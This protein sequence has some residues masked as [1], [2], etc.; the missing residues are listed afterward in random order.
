MIGIIKLQHMR[1]NIC[2]CIWNTFFKL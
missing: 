1:M 2:I